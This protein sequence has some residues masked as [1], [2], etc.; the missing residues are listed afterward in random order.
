[1]TFKVWKMKFLNFMTSQ[2]FHDLYEP[3]VD[4]LDYVLYTGEFGIE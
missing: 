4:L 2:V 3:C 1:M